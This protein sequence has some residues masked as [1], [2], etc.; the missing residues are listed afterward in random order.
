MS[1]ASLLGTPLPPRQR[2]R[3]SAPSPYT[4][5]QLRSRGGSEQT[6]TERSVTPSG[7]DEDRSTTQQLASPTLSTTSTTHSS[8]T[9]RPNPS[10]PSK[11]SS[12]QIVPSQDELRQQAQ[13]AV[14]RTRILTDPSLSSAFRRD[15]DNE[16]Y[17]LFVGP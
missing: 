6:S 13:K 1:N 11:P 16:L 2:E 8:S 5:H 9:N 12:S 17:E 15:V 4:P 14:Q 3:S 10:S 7:K